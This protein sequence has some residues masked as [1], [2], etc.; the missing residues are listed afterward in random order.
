MREKK[1]RDS[2][3][4]SSFSFLRPVRSFSFQVSG[5]T[6][7]YRKRYQLLENETFVSNFQVSSEESCVEFHGKLLGHWKPHEMFEKTMPRVNCVTI[8]KTQ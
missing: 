2:L 7:E 4:W 1:E 3:V 5:I 6:P 8:S